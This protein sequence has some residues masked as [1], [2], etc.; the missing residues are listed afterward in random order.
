MSGS[1]TPAILGLVGVLIGGALAFASNLWIAIVRDRAER[2][3]IVESLSNER[4]R[5]ARLLR[6]EL[7]MTAAVLTAQIESKK[8]TSEFERQ[9]SLDFWKQY[10]PVL[11]QELSIEAWRALIIA[12]GTISVI[13][14]ESHLVDPDLSESQILSLKNDVGIIDQAIEHLKSVYE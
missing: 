6:A 10:A 12:Y 2:A 4:K 9:I 1:L 5:A 7:S 8:W 14:T 13:L 11:A 3:K